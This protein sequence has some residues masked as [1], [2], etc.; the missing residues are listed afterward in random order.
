MA[1]LCYT[2]SILHKIFKRKDPTYKRNPYGL[3]YQH[4]IVK[5]MKNMLLN[6]NKQYYL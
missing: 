1:L 6:M 4:V 5:Q 3:I 2:W